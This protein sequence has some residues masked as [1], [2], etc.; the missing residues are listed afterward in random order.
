MSETNKIEVGHVSRPAQCSAFYQVRLSLRR[1]NCWE[2]NLPA[3]LAQLIGW[4]R[5]RPYRKT[6]LLRLL[7]DVRGQEDHD[8]IVTEFENGLVDKAQHILNEV[9]GGKLHAGED[10]PLPND[11][12]FKR[13]RN[14]N[15]FI[16]AGNLIMAVKEAAWFSSANP[17]IKRRLFQRLWVAPGKVVIFREDGRGRRLPLLQAD[18]RS[19]RQI[20]PEG[21]NP[22]NMF[23]AK[24]A[25]LVFAERVNAPA[26]LSFIFCV[27]PERV[28]EADLRGWLTIAGELGIM[29]FHQERQGQFDIVN[30][31]PALPQTVER[32]LHREATKEPEQNDPHYD[33]YWIAEEA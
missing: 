32:L 7:E 12:C 30:L 21:P 33:R 27:D 22:G 31:H 5:S 2:A 6:Q 24:P 28:S 23:R 16:G 1:G 19:Q 26:Y 9:T 10:S 14:C 18:G 20:P 15:L 13:T 29:G 8:R 17:G 25:R 3:T 4:L 11:S